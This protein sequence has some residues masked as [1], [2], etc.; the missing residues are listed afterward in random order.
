MT[1]C[2]VDDDANCD[3]PGVVCTWAGSGLRAFDGDGRDRRDT[4]LYWPLDM[5]FAPD[6]RAYLIDWQN[7]R[8]RRVEADD[9]VRTVVG[10][11]LPGDGPPDQSDLTEDGAP[12]TSVE[13]NHPTDLAFMADGRMLIAAW[14]NHKI[15]R[16]DPVT[17]K[18]RVL[19]GSGPGDTRERTLAARAL[20]NQ[21]KSVAVDG[22]GKVFVADSRNQRLRLIDGEGVLSAVAGTGLRGFSGDGGPPMMATFHMQQSNENP[23]P[24]GSIALDALGRIYLADTFN[25]R[26]RR[27][28][29]QADT[30]ET[31][32]GNGTGGFGGDGGPAVAAAL[33]RPRD[34]EFGPD[35]R[36][37]VADTDNHRIR[38]IDLTSGIIETIAG[39]ARRGLGGD[40]G[41]A[42]AAALD[43]PFG[44]AFDAQGNLYVAD[45]F[46]DRI[47]RVAAPSAAA[48]Q[49]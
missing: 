16:F 39:G 34:L 18:V 30:V 28:D 9:R 15:R 25:N 45:T 36:L 22:S 12:G 31:I 7:H 13:L 29:L 32:A 35:G 1:G 33:N 47:R 48:R 5:E 44:V 2:A 38:V 41:L 40:G 3:A 37:Y 11:D 26:I 23:E 46:N 42:T 27:I 17:G 21:P 20:L 4:G 14:H 19:C 49:P 43:R 24:G 8:I 6:G 10:G